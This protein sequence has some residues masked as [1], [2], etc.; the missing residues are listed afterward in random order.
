MRAG[1]TL[2]LVLAC[3][4][5][6]FAFSAFLAMAWDR[7]HVNVHPLGHSLGAIEVVAACIG[8]LGFELAT[9][10]LAR[11]RAPATE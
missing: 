4:A 7:G 3:S 1:F 10:A 6:G 9:S 11:R 8:A 2:T 5:V